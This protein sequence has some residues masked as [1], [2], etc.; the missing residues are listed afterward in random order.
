MA[1]AHGEFDQT[2]SK[3]AIKFCLRCEPAF[4]GVFVIAAQVEELNAAL[5]LL[6]PPR[7]STETQVDALEI[8]RQSLRSKLP[9]TQADSTRTGASNGRYLDFQQQERT[10]VEPGR[11]SIAGTRA[12]FRY[13]LPAWHCHRPDS[14]SDRVPKRF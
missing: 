7:V 13:G 5:G 2:L 8:A 10:G 11:R 12:R 9:P 14:R 6:L 4:E 3:L 1:A